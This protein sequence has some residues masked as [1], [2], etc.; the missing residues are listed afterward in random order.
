MEQ[1]KV[2]ANLM[3]DGIVAEAAVEP[4]PDRADSR[5][6]GPAVE[7]RVEA[8]NV[9]V[10]VPVVVFRVER[11]GGVTALRQQIVVAAFR[12]GLVP[13]R[14]LGHPQHPRHQR[15]V[16]REFPIRVVAEKLVGAFHRE[17]RRLVVERVA[18][19]VGEV[20]ADEQ[21]A[22]FA[23]GP[24]HGRL[25]LGH[26]PQMHR[27]AKRLLGSDEFL[28]PSGRRRR[29]VERAPRAGQRQDGLIRRK[30]KRG[31]LG[32]GKFAGRLVGNGHLPAKHNAVHRQATLGSK[33]RA[34]PQ[35]AR[36]QALT[37]QL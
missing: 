29:G 34:P 5:L 28:L 22:F 31:F 36:R 8:D 32:G 3:L 24:R 27:R 10:V 7:D 17:R 37:V 20:H 23:G 14:R 11:P 9:Q 13:R 26:R 21:D 25:L 35:P 15:H 16:D 4:K 12:L 1:A 18:L 6:A 33:V 30:A 2:V 19:A